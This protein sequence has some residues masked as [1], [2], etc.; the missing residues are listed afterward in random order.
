MLLDNQTYE[1][2]VKLADSEYRDPRAQ[3]GLMLREELKR[4]GLLECEH[5]LNFRG[6]K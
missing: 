6:A 2:L 4:R 5:E 1:A 3:A